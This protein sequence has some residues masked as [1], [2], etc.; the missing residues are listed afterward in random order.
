[1][2]PL[3]REIAARREALR[4]QQALP[5][6]AKRLWGLALS[7]GGIRSATFCFGLLRALAARSML[8]RFDLLS[9]V[10]GGGYIG[11]MLGRLYSRAASAADV[12]TITRA[13]ADADGRWFTWW[14]RANGRYLVPRG[15]RD[16]TFALALYLRNL[17]GV[18][19]E[20]GLLA[21]LLA[22][23]LGSLDALGWRAL[24]TLATEHADALFPLL[25]YLPQH[26]PVV[27]L[28]ALPPLA[29]AGFVVAGAYWC[30]PWL[31]ASTRGPW[32]A[33]AAIFGGGAAIA[34]GGPLLVHGLDLLHTEVGAPQR[35][36]LVWFV[37]VL[38]LVGVLAVPLAEALLNVRRGTAARA[39]RADDV[40]NRLTRW[41]GNVLRAGLL[42]GLAALVDALAWWLAFEA[43][44][45]VQTGVLL[46]LAAAVVRAL[47]PSAAAMAGAHAGADGRR[48]GSPKFAIALARL[49]GYALT[50]ALAA[51]WASIV[52]Q[53]ALGAVF[54]REP[55]Y[56]AALAVLVLLGA[57][58]A[59]YLLLTGTGIDFL[60][61]SSLHP[62]YRA[63]LVRAY[64][65]AANPL[66][67]AS[68]D[69]LAAIGELPAAPS[70]RPVS[71]VLPDDDLA[72]A[73]YRP[74]LHGAPVHVVNCCI[75]ETKDPRGGL[76]NQ[77]RRGLALA[78]AA[79]G[80]MQVSRQGWQPHDGAGRLS[81]GRWIAISGAAVAPGLGSLTRGGISALAMYAGVRLGYWWSRDARGAAAPMSR[82][83]KSRGLLRETFGAF[84]A[85]DA[86]D[87]F[88]TDGGHFE[89]TA[90]YAL[91]AERAEVVVLADCGADPAYAF[92]DLEN[93]VRKARIDLQAEVLFLRPRTPLPAPPPPDRWQPRL[94]AFGS[95]A[96]LGSSGSSACLA[97]ARIVYRGRDGAPDAHG[98]LVIVK[99]NMSAGLP[100][101]LVNFHREHPEFP[102]QPTADQFFDEAQW[103]SYFQLGSYLGGQLDRELIEHLLQHHARYFEADE[104][105]PF[106]EGAIARP[107]GRLAQRIGSTAVNASVGL[108]AAATLGVSLWTAMDSVRTGWARQTA[109]ERA[110]L[111]EL[112]ELWARLPAA[113]ASAAPTA[114]PN[115]ATQ[116]LALNQLAA[117]IVRTAD[118]LCPAGEA[119]WFQ[120]SPV[121]ATIYADA[122]RGCERQPE[123][124]ACR[125]LIESATPRLPTRLPNCLQPQSGASTRMPRYWVYDYDA[126]AAT[127]DAHPCDP[128]A[129]EREAADTAYRGGLLTLAQLRGGAE[130]PVRDCRGGPLTMAAAPAPP[131]APASPP[132]PAAPDKVRPAPA[133]TPP[134]ASEPVP[135]PAPASVCA[136]RTV[137]LQVYGPEQRDLARSWREPWRALGLSVPPI[138]DVNTSARRNN[139]MAP[140]PVPQVTVRFHDAAS[141]ACAEQLGPTVGRSDWTVEPLSASLKPLPGVI[142]VWVPPARKAAAE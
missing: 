28:A 66:R 11:G 51:W 58:A 96:D 114:P 1:M 133:T 57:G 83:A 18:H 6:G 34:V 64:L 80:L 92:G 37:G 5:D 140:R 78:V 10:S 43:R 95:L 67:Y 76:F 119:G 70:A 3:Q 24:D 32:L 16:R 30:V 132:S 139:R 142:E 21:V 85:G 41:L 74:H 123:L 135:S 71:D 110:A 53:A 12:A 25:R 98:L 115:D 44:A 75:N 97:L 105:G 52:Y 38:A 87:W 106:E 72:L 138:E 88:L 59:G 128:Q 84:R 40:R 26:L 17:V 109:D 68:T 65:G 127:T 19:I 131:V 31:A 20:L 46:A 62:F 9:T 14:L 86:A 35:R 124:P 116:G 39:E 2:T 54:Q 4:G 126:A 125:T 7:G 120:R 94:Q 45:L 63:R 93:L 121:A 134:A 129:G 118:T 122:M 42:V 141:R 60:N 103:E 15:A 33:A 55:S 117:T 130:L 23:G 47:A 82:T 111:K 69:A 61:L 13:L 22:V 136:G 107:V 81:L 36:A 91:L 48:P 8:L 101:D 89:N 137:Y 79:G 99:P 27:V 49:L 112:T 50:L 100:V 90:A 108:G 102:Q 29:L 77:D 104:R 56:G 113:P 73:D